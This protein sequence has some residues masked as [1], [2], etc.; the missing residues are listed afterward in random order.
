MEVSTL[1]AQEIADF[2]FLEA[3]RL[4]R[5]DVRGWLDLLTE[6]ID[7]RVPIR[8]VREKAV[9]PV[10]S[11]FSHRGHLLW[12][13]R[14]TLQTRVRRL[15]SE[16]AWAEQP[17]TRTRRM[18]GNIRRRELVDG[19]QTCELRA[20]TNIAVYCYRADLPTPVVLTGERDDLL[21]LVDGDLRLAR[22]VVYLDSNV[23]GTHALS[24]FL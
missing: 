18:V 13:N 14:G 7:Y 22:R 8:V 10:E 4:D 6:D 5:A 20:L 3:E 9:Q 12:E 21:R 24:I 17:P 15:E 11:D 2:Y 16:F 19:D 23:L 1:T